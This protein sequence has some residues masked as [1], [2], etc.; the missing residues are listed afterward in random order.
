MAA[1]T[2]IDHTELTGSATTWS[3]SSISASYDHL[4]LEFSARSDN[5]SYR[6][7]IYV[8]LNGDT[9]T[10]YSVTQLFAV[11]ATPGSQRQSGVASIQKIYIPD[12]SNTA[13]TFGAGSLWIPNY[14]NTANFK[15]VLAQAA[16]SDATTTDYR[17]GLALAAGLWSS[18]AAV[19]QITLGPLTGTNFVQYSTFTLYGVT[20]A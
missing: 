15:Q 14:A 18:T 19:N 10:N 13:D 6:D 17:W 2:V 7:E 9:G 5:T 3:E 11:S 1:F 4:Y 16:S 12:A 20:G 8:Q